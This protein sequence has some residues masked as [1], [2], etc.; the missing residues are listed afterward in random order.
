[1]QEEEEG[2][3]GGRGRGQQRELRTVTY[4]WKKW[5]EFVEWR[6]LIHRGARC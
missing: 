1:M 5:R 4:G 3:M 6:R 2:R